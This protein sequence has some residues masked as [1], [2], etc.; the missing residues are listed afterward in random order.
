VLRPY[1]NRSQ[2]NTMALGCTLES[3]GS[4]RLPSKLA[5]N[6]VNNAAAVYEN[7]M[8][9]S[10]LG[11]SSQTFTPQKCEPSVQM[12]VVMPARTWHGGPM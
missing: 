1:M 2:A 8:R 6:R 12:G 7:Q 4:S 10:I 3:G 11:K 5:V 9:R